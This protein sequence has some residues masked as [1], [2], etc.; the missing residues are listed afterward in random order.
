MPDD[1]ASQTLTV[2]IFLR[3]HA[4]SGASEKDLLSGAY[5]PESRESAAAAMAADPGDLE[6]TREFA[7][8]Y[9]LQ[10]VDENKEARRIQVRGTAAQLNKA[11]GVRLR[12]AT[13]RTDNAI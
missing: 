10:I 2:S 13:A 5:H 4:G 6:M 12:W 11:F 9:G 3:R 1:A 8:Q 7:E